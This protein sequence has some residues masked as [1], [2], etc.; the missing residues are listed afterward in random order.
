MEER[1][2]EYKR[3]K[4]MMPHC[5]VCKEQLRGDNSINRPWECS[6]GVWESANM[7]DYTGAYVIVPPPPR[8]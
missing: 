3:V 5:P 1:R 6:C 2:P 8:A 4:V 7:F